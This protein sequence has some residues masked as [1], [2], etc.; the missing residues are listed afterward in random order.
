M[1]R[2]RRQKSAMKKN[3]YTNSRRIVSAASLLT[4][5][6]IAVVALLQTSCGSK[7]TVYDTYDFDELIRYI[8]ETTEGRELF[9]TEGLV[10]DFQYTKP[11]D[12]DA[13]FRDLLDSTT[14]HFHVTTTPD[15][16]EKE[17][18]EPF[19]IVDDAE[20]QVRD[21]FYVRIQRVEE[22][23]TS[24]KYQQRVLD[25]FAYFLRFSSEDR[26]YRGWRMHAYN[27]G[28][29]REGYMEITPSTGEMFR[30]DGLQ[31]HHFRYMMHITVSWY[32]DDK[33]LDSVTTITQ[34][35]RSDRGYALL[36]D[37]GR[38]RKGDHLSVDEE[39]EP[40]AN[41][42]YQFISAESADGPVYRL[43]HRPDSAH[44]VDTIQTPSATNRIWD[45]ICFFEF[46]F[47][48]RPGGIWCV[49]YHTQ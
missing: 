7:P 9:R 46:Q 33:R 19:G 16:V 47:V 24:I 21:V 38:V 2:V 12:P 11:T 34:L 25:R 29:P 3:R 30:G 44:Y 13:V 6:G 40:Y 36:E 23:D 32:G 27:G 15:T 41:S 8:Q 37:I 45:I 48:D 4:V 5:L 26:P 17:H 35:G 39:T 10:R 14:R 18:G 31:F 20:V 42:V 28:T 49:P 22:T 43:I 1:I